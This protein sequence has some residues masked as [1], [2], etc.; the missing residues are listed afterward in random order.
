MGR[1]EQGLEGICQSISM[2]E[3]QKLFFS[4]LQEEASEANSAGRLHEKTSGGSEPSREQH[5]FDFSY[6]A[7]PVRRTSG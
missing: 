3:M 5:M 4:A 2:S 7:R 6:K 1:F